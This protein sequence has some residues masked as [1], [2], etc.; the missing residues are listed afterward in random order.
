MPGAQRPPDAGGRNQLHPERIFGQA[1]RH[2]PEIQESERCNTEWPADKLVLASDKADNLDVNVPAWDIPIH[3]G[4]YHDG[5]KAN[6]LWCDG[7]ASSLVKEEAK[8]SYW[9]PDGYSGRG[10]LFGSCSNIGAE[11]KRRLLPSLMKE[12]SEKNMFLTGFADEAAVDIGRP[13]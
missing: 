13:D 6:I 4:F 8:V 1:D 3:I 9:V 12:K 5:G 11:V 10:I 2:P 7:H